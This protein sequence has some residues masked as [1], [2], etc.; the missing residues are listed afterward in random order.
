MCA[1]HISTF[2]V[3]NNCLPRMI[4]CQIDTKSPLAVSSVEVLVKREL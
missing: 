2:R 3:V 4:V 1:H